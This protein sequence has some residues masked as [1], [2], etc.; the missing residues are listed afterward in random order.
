M[1]RHRCAGGLKKL[2]LRSGSQRHRHFAGFFNVPILHRHGTNLFIQWFRHTAPI[3]RL[4]RHAGDTED[5]FSSWTPGVLTGV[6][7]VDDYTVQGL[8]KEILSEIIENESVPRSNWRPFLFINYSLCLHFAHRPCLLTWYI[9]YAQ[10]TFTWTF[11][12]LSP[13]W[14]YPCK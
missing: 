9:N 6:K 14:L 10:S 5:V 2:Y 11:L 13:G 7:Q 12:C 8:S 1:W 3:S 4:S